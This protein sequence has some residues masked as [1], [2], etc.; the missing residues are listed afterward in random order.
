MEP[1]GGR[2]CDLFAGSGTVA[3]A[4]SL[5]RPVI[6]ADIQEYSRVLC[7]AVLNPQ[8]QAQP[9]NLDAC[10]QSEN[11]EAAMRSLIDYEE[12]CIAASRV[13]NPKALVDFV[14]NSSLIRYLS[15]STF[16]GTKQLEDL[17]ERS[18]HQLQQGNLLYSSMSVCTRWF[19]G[20][21]F[22][23][24]QAVQLDGLLQYAFTVE[25]QYR[26]SL[27]AAIMSTASEI[28]NTVGKHFAQPLRLV[29]RQGRIKGHLISKTISDR[30]LE[31]LPIFMKWCHAYSTL[32]RQTRPH[33]VFRRDFADTLAGLPDDTAIIYADPPYTRD[34]YSRFYHVLETLCL[35]DEPI[36]SKVKSRSGPSISRGIYRQGRHQSPFSIPSQARNAFSELFHLASSRRIPLLMSYS[37]YPNNEKARPRLL[38]LED[39]VAVASARYRTVEVRSLEM[40]HNKLNTKVLNQSKVLHAEALI[41]CKP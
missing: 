24:K 36:S 8:W 41:L 23:F 40:S 33:N 7:S 38:T 29:D 1:T 12:E 6:A 10:A 11:L 18:T 26:D 30:S 21:Y 14:E 16:E 4:L 9:R 17:L 5:T 25:H 20:V 22:S 39:M 31:V 35:R 2:V 37:P 27:L 34:H 13:G 19:G 15:G 3:Q 28:T 32:P